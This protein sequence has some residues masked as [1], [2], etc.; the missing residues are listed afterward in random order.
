LNISHIKYLK[1]LSIPIC[2]GLFLSTKIDW[3]FFGHRKINRMAVFTLPQEMLP[4]YKKYISYL[5][6]HSID[7]DARRYASKFEAVRHYIDLDQWVTYPVID[8]PQDFEST[9]TKYGKFEII[10][11]DEAIDS[12]SIEVDNNFIILNQPNSPTVKIRRTRWIG[13]FK[14][15]IMNQYY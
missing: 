8:L 15:Y 10:K 9:L 1:V 3:G 4:V 13:F 11:K 2:L 12:I 5:E 6:E 14:H 7:P